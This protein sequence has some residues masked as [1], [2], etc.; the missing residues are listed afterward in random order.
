MNGGPSISYIEKHYSHVL[1]VMQAKEL[2]TKKFK[3]K[4]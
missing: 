1:T 3:A 4:A 2:Q